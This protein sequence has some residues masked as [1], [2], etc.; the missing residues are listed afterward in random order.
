MEMKKDTQMLGCFIRRNKSLNTETLKSK[1]CWK[2]NF[3]SLNLNTFSQQQKN[4]SQYF[5][6]NKKKSLVHTF[7]LILVKYVYTTRLIY[8]TYIIFR[9]KKE[10]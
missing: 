7:N 4:M 2:L 6:G 3:L 5:A 8:T 10:E 1:V 9:F